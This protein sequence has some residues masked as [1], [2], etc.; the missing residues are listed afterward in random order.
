MSLCFSFKKEML[1]Y[2][3]KHALYIRFT[4]LGMAS[5]H[6]IGNVLG[7]HKWIKHKSHNFFYLTVFYRGIFFLCENACCARGR[8]TDNS[9]C[10]YTTSRLII[11]IVLY[12]SDAKLL[13]L[14]LIMDNF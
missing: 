9:T 10:K 12:K 6:I 11:I 5:T 8:R 2:L 14:I 13:N 3:K 1:H 4:L 7:V